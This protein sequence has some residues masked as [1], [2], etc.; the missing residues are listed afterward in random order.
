MINRPFLLRELFFFFLT[1]WAFWS[2]YSVHFFKKYF[3]NFLPGKQPELTTS[4]SSEDEEGRSGTTAVRRRRLRKNTTSIVTEDEELDMSQHE[5]EEEEEDAQQLEMQTDVKASSLGVQNVKEH[6]SSVLNKCIMVALIIALSMGF[7]HFHGKNFT[8]VVNIIMLWLCVRFRSLD[9]LAFVVVLIFSTNRSA[10]LNSQQSVYLHPSQ[11]H[12]FHLHHSYTFWIFQSFSPTVLSVAWLCI[13]LVYR[14]DSNSGKTETCRENQTEG[15]RWRERPASAACWRASA[16]KLGQWSTLKQQSPF[17]QNNR[18]WNLPPLI[19]WLSHSKPK[20]PRLIREAVVSRVVIAVI[21]LCCWSLSHAELQRCSTF[22][23]WAADLKII[24]TSFFPH[25][26][27]FI[28]AILWCS[29]T[30]TM[31]NSSAIG[32]FILRCRTWVSWK[33][34]WLFHSSQKL[35]KSY[36]KKTRSSAPNRHRFRLVSKLV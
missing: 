10:Y 18:L 28:L 6:K 29:H 30:K 20:M 1:A 2:K 9:C 26:L 21:V 19:L 25:Q 24:W 34:K 4:S 13:N 31:S 5:E 8:G 36:K 27:F 23:W 14:H 3:C 17:H 33:S 7:G 32:S 22:V 11:F 35:W 15:T 16:D 12:S